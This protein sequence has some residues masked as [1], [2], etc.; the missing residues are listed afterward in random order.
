MASES[1]NPDDL[2]LAIKELE[3]FGV[4]YERG[5]D[6]LLA[7]DV[8]ASSDLYKVYDIL[9]KYL[10]SGLWD[11]EEAHVGHDIQSI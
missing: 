9:E 5:H 3:S 2:A 11:F 1:A 10:R 7:L 4:G 8:P 6:K